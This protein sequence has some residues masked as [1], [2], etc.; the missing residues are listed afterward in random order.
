MRLGLTSSLN[1]VLFQKWNFPPTVKNKQ[2]LKILKRII[3]AVVNPQ[4]PKGKIL[5]V[6]RPK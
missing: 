4:V 2:F 5:T 6:T 3:N 1:K